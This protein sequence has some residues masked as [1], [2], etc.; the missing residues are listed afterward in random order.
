M[1]LLLQYQLNR[2]LI[3]Y[4]GRLAVPEDGWNRVSGNLTSER[5]LAINA[6]LLVTWRHDERRRSYSNI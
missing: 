6:D 1:Q 3:T 5:H 4:L 2:S